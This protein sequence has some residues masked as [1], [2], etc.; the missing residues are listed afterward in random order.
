MIVRG[1]KTSP[2]LGQ[3][4]T[5]RRD[6]RL[7]AR[8]DAEPEEQPDDRAD[9]ADHERLEQHRP[10]HL[11]A[12]GA[13]G[14]QG[15]ELAHPLRNRDRE[16]VG[17]HEAPDE[18]RDT[19]EAEQ[20]V[21]HD[22]HPLLG[23]VAVLGRLDLGRLHLRRLGEERPDLARELRLRHAGLRADADQVELALLAE[24]PLGGREVEDRDRGAGDRVDG[25][26]ADDPADPVLLDR[27]VAVGADRLADLQLLGLGG[28]LVDRDLR[29]RRGASR[30]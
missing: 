23:L 6:E 4:G 5:R 27:A 13:E 3:L 1:A 15:G 9:E 30:R 10:E 26:E 7:Q 18:Q 17:D 11:P 21:L 20:E 25:A 16:R 28:G 2:P 14:P 19:A 24:Q 12:R 8:G 22:A 29:R